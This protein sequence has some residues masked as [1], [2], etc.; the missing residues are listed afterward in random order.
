[1]T[2]KISRRAFSGAGLAGLGALV[3][4]R[5][6]FA[7]TDY[8]TKPIRIIVPFGAAG[9]SDIS[10]RLLQNPLQQALGQPLIIE[11]R[12]GAGSNI[13]SAVVARSDPDGYT[14][15]IT[16]S[17]FVVNPTLYAKP[18]YDAYK[19]FVPLADI[20]D[21]PNVLLASKASGLKTLKDAIAYAKANP[22]KLNVASPGVGTTPHLSIELLKQRAD[23][24][25]VAIPYQ[26]GG[27]AAQAMIAGQTDLFVSALP[28][29]Y[30]QLQAGAMTAL[31]IA[32]DKHWPG[33][34][35]VPTFIESGFPGFITATGHL[36][37][38]PG[39]T[40]P[41][42]AKK[43]SD[44][45]VASIKRKE[46]SEQFVKL[47]YFPVGGGMD[48]AKARIAHDIPFYGVIITKAGL[49]IE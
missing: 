49:K 25:I 22:G 21:A 8:P 24:N 32:S 14:L 3:T 39:G 30:G 29:I 48:A 2:I 26:G 43:L 31:A 28:N 20:A 15:M 45:A 17:A 37:L 46:I 40:P 35:D 42:I 34:P 16:S 33:L 47:G 13:G 11:N 12:P 4:R 36:F 27:P 19:Q 41:E 7:S 9:S 23:I 1:M 6:A 44:A 10:A 5:G 18:T 38:A